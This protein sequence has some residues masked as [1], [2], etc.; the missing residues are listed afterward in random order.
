MQH[1]IHVSREISFC[2][3]PF[4]P[5]LILQ[6]LLQK[7][8]ARSISSGGA[9][10]QKT[11]FFD[12]LQ[13]SKGPQRQA[14]RPRSVYRYSRGSSCAVSQNTLR[15]KL[16][17]GLLSISILCKLLPYKETRKSSNTCVLTICGFF[18]TLKRGTP[19]G[20]PLLGYA[21]TAGLPFPSERPCG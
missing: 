5:A 4:S 3:L 13:R 10:C 15:S 6:L 16:F 2:S 18:D 11:S 1:T 8:T 20:V 14:T 9:V 17:V 12:R 21:I 19:G 7:I